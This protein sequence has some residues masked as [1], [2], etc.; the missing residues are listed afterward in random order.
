MKSPIEVM[1][2]AVSRIVEEAH[3]RL[4]VVFGSAVRGDVHENSD[5]DLM[6]VMP[7][8][9][10]RLEAAKRLCR[11]LRDLGCAKDIVVVLESEVEALRDNPNMI[12]HTALTEG[13]IAYRAA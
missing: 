7:D 6:V 3:P 12:V 8:G 4:V 2:E 10:D 13:R 11:C 9:T 5:L 1:D